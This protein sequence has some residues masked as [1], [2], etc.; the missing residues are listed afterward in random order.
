MKKLFPLFLSA[1]S[2]VSQQMI[3]AIKEEAYS[4]EDPKHQRAMLKYAD[5]LEKKYDRQIE[6]QKWIKEY[7][8]QTDGS[9]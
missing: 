2:K 5:E 8:R 9:R 6:E 3:D 4:F 7:L 1:T